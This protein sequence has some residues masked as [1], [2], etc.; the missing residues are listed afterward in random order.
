MNGRCTQES[1]IDSK[2]PDYYIKKRI[3]LIVANRRPFVRPLGIKVDVRRAREVVSDR[4]RTNVITFV[5]EHILFLCEK[6]SHSSEMTPIAK[7]NK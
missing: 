2:R 7:T 6:V 4:I 5:R 3:V 1:L